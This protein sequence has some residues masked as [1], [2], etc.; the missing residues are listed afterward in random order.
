MIAAFIIVVKIEAVVEHGA[1]LD[2]WL[3]AGKHWLHEQ[4]QGD[5]QS[6]YLNQAIQYRVDL[7][8]MDKS[9]IRALEN[10]SEAKVR[11][12]LCRLAHL[13]N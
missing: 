11:S 8:A 5:T 6:T 7:A 12:S 4:G 3:E 13:V 1:C 2:G 10:K 9:L